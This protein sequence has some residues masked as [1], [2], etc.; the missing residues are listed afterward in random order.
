MPIPKLQNIKPHLKR[1]EIGAM[2]NGIEIAQIGKVLRTTTEV[3]RFFDDLSEKLH[4][5]TLFVL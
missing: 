1:L 3:T 4:H 2:L 5:D